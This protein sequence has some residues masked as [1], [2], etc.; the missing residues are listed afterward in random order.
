MNRSLKPF[1]AVAAVA[2][3]LASPSIHAQ[4]KSIY[5][6]SEEGVSGVTSLM[7]AVASGDVN[8]VKFFTK[9]GTSLIN[10]KNLGG[11]TAL[12]LACREG[13]F[14][15]V[16]V[17]VDSGADVNVADN[18]GWTALMRAA[19]AGDKNSVDLLLT[20]KDVQAAATNS[21]GES[22]LIHAIYSNCNECLSSMFTKYDFVKLGDL[23]ALRT[24]LSDA[25]VAAKNRDNQMAQDMISAY[26]N[27]LPQDSSGEN[28]Q[29]APTTKQA[30]TTTGQGK[31][32]I[33]KS[34]GQVTSVVETELTPMIVKP[35]KS[36]LVTTQPSQ[37]QGSKSFASKFKLIVGEQGKSRKNSKKIG[38]TKSEN[39][40]SSVVLEKSEK[41][42]DVV[43]ETAPTTTGSVYK[44][45]RGP[46]GK[47]IK[48]KA[49]KKKELSSSASTTAAAPVA[50]EQ[51]A[52]VVVELAKPAEDAVVTKPAAGATSKI[53][54]PAPVAP[55]PAPVLAA[56]ATK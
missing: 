37:Q 45:N 3:L 46:E 27:R 11:A 13:N 22:A 10:Q 51:A 54:D 20:T 39:S 12:H 4:I 32:F 53:I 55:V 1:L 34:D 6:T 25:F 52:P 29:A 18:E 33:F 50:I 16:K 48:R 31:K 28:K 24:Q 43:I 49:I 42:E 26:L 2:V 41:V 23:N 36:A 40:E 5:D 44:F 47:I 15:I 9:S 14:E 17:L 21:M 38:V 35:N 56:P 19:M 8:G 30:P 7:S